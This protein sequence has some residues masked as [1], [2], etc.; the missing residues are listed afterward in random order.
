M[1]TNQPL[2]DLL[3]NNNS[4]PTLPEVV[5]RIQDLIAQEDAGTAEIGA[6]VAEDPPLAA[7]VL[8]IANSSFYGLAG[9]CMSTEHASTVLGV[10]V[11]K[12]IVT[13]V[14]VMDLFEHVENPCLNVADLWSHAIFTAQLCSML[15]ERAKRAGDLAPEEYYVCGLL[16][17]VGKLVMLDGLGERYFDVI[18]ASSERD[19]P[20]HQVEREMLSFTHTDVGAM[21]AKRWDLPENVGNA[22]QYHHGPRSRV[23]GDPV[24]SLVA[25]SN[26][27]AHRLTE[28]GDTTG[29]FDEETCRQLG[30]TQDAVDFVSQ[31]AQTPGQEAA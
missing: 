7:K 1:S 22:I 20:L 11:L 13:Q 19:V 16:H 31:F 30:L 27:L 25:H 28:G 29:I 6:L 5:L 24:V 3:R 12:N 8:R 21:V 23:A 14:A 17:D 2:Q 26:L 10:K 4:I 9:E 15:A 18:R